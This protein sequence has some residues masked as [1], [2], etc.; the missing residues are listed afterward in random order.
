VKALV[1]ATFAGSIFPHWNYFEAGA[2]FGES[3][4]SSIVR[5]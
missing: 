1:L 5:M 3:S 2:D 4:K